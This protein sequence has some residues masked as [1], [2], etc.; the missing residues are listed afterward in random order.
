MSSISEVVGALQEADSVCIVAHLRPDA[1][2]LGSMATLRLALEQL[3]KTTRCVV[4]QDWPISENLFTIPGTET[5]EVVT[6]LPQGYDLYVTVDCGSLDR[7]GF[8]APGLAK[9]IRRGKVVCID[10]HA[11]NHGFGNINLVDVA[12]E[13][14]TTVLAPVLE[15]LGVRLNADIAHAMYAGLVTD[16]GSFRWG[17][18]YMHTFAGQLMEYGLDTK[19]IS[20]DL[21]D[22]NTAED[23]QMLGRVLA[24]VEIIPAGEHTMAVLVGRYDVISGH[25]DSAVE[26]MVD[27]VRALDGTDLGVVFKE[28]VPGFWAVSLRS[29][30]VNCA[31]VAARL[32]GGGHVP[33]AGYSTRGEPEEIIAELADIVGQF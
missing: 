29:N 23:L 18:P 3:G 12:C 10:H 19:Q 32:G 2:A 24:D 31:Q 27:F 25:S 8:L 21:M 9:M 15:E 4:G 33:A 14:T 1:D 26:T 5:V 6:A 17:R 20:V 30:G 11:S 16:T 22:S 13:S 7:T 28:Q